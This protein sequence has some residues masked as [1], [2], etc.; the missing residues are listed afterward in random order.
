ML[1]LLGVDV[2]SAGVAQVLKTFCGLPHRCQTVR[3]HNKVTYV[4]DSKGTNVG[5]TLAALQGLGTSHRKNILLI[6]GGE[7]K[8]A[9][10]KALAKPMTDFVRVVYLFGKDAARI[11]DVVP[12]GTEV[13]LFESLDQIVSSVDQDSQEGDIVLFSPA[14]ASLDMYKKYEARGDHFAQLVNALLVNAL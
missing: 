5:A 3:V 12:K 14:C 13:K 7:G 10:F 1:E 2:K 9:D 4:N 6:A 11:A 8:G